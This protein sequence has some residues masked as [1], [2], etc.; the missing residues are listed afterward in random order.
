M[1]RLHGVMLAGLLVAGFAFSPAS[2]A[3][4]STQTGFTLEQVLSYP[5]PLDLTSAHHGDRIV[6]VIDQNGVR[7]V[8]V[9]KAP[10]FKPHQATRFTQDDGQEITQ[11]TFSPSGNALVFVRGGDHD[12]NWPVKVAVDPASSPVEP[13]VM[14]WTVDLHANTA[15]ELTEGD[16]PALSSD[17][18]LAYIKD[19]QVWTAPLA[20]NDKTKPKQLFFDHGKLLE[21]SAPE[22]FFTSPKDLRAQAF[23]RQVL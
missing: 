15:R 8:W 19:G 18:K 20:A 21:D 6:W 12:A 13:K 23:L 10:E 1:Y 9:A 5:F 2:P 14:I 4:A 3:A 22:D 7:N 17:G 11:L 16:A